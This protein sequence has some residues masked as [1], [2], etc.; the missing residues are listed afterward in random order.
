MKCRAA[1]IERFEEAASG[2]RV[3]DDVALPPLQDSEIEIAVVAAAVNPVDCLVRQGYGAP[4]LRRYGAPGFPRILGCDVAGVVSAVGRD[5]EGFQLGDRV[6]AAVPPWRQGTYAERVRVPAEWVARAPDRVALRD[7]AALP[8][9]GRVVWQALV[10]AAGLHRTRGQRVFVHAG[11]G[12]VGSI[13][14]QLAKAW[15]HQVGTT[16][17]PANVDFLRELGADQVVDYTKERFDE[18]C[19]DYDVVFNTLAPD[20]P[21]WDER[22]HL[23]VL[24]RG[25]TYVTVIAPVM[26][27]ATKLGVAPGLALAGALYCVTAVWQRLVHARRYHWILFQPDGR[28][29]AGLARYVDDGLLRPVIRSRYPL[30]EVVVAQQDCERAHGRGKV[31]IDIADEQELLARFGNDQQAQTQGTGG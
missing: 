4:L 6:W 28:T 12:G 9:T 8:Y 22:P 19:R 20:P 18:V 14:I 24:R 27:L 3:V 23:R 25:G 15:G 31:M 13:A 1:V 16:C 5:V 30:D 21:R 17:G 7:A 10:E 2:L 26:H 29:L 11:A